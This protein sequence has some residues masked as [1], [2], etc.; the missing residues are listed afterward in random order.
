MGLYTVGVG[1]GYLI[2]LFL[3]A[4]AALSLAR[5]RDH[6]DEYTTDTI[7]DGFENRHWC[8]MLNRLNLV[9]IFITLVVM[10]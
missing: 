4:W 1:T 9:E 5:I 10:S 7:I 3:G 2:V 8:S 6:T